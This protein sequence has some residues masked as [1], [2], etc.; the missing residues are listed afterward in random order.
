MEEK[1]Q[2]KHLTRATKV[3]LGIILT[4][5]VLVVMLAAALYLPP[6][7]RW[8]V[9]RASEYASRETGMDISVGGVHLAFPLD[10]S[11][12]EVKCIK[13]NDSLP[14]VRDTIA[15]I[16]QAVVDVQLLPL[17]NSNVVINQVEIN[18]AH[19][20][21]S[22]FIHEARVK[23]YVGRL[24]I[25]N[26][27]PPVATV[28]LDSS[29]V[30]LSNVIMSDAKLDVALSDTVPPDTTESEN[31]WKIYASQFAVHNSQFTVHM[32]G[33]TLQVSASL[34]DA[35]A[36]EGFFDLNKGLYQIAQFT[37]DSSQFTLDNNFEPTLRKSLAANDLQF[38]ANHIALTDINL[39]VDSI[40]Y[41]DPDIRL[42][43]LEASMKEQGGLE[44]KSMTARVAIDS[45][46]MVVDGNLA[47][48]ASTM[49]LNLKMRPNPVT[50]L[51]LDNGEIDG[52]IDASIG[53]QD[54]M[55]FAG[56][57]LPKNLR[58]QWPQAP[59]T[60]KGVMHGNM[61][62]VYIPW[63]TAELPTA[64]S[65]KASGNA[66]GFMA[67]ADNPYSRQFSAKMHA[68]L[69]TYNLN[70]VKALLD[71]STAKIINIP[72]MH[73]VADVTAN[74][75]EYWADV[76]AYERTGT[77][78]GKVKANIAANR[79]DVDAKARNINVGHYV[80]GYNQFLVHSA[81]LAVHN[82]IVNANVD[83]RSNL[84]YG[85]INV[86]G[87]LGSKITDLAITTDLKKADLYK[88][89][90]ADMPL[91]V[92]LNGQVDV[93]TDMDQYYKVQG[94]V[95]E[96]E[97]TDSVTTHHLGDVALDVLTRRDTTAAKINCGDFAMQ[98]NAQGGYK[99]LMG[100]TDRMQATLEK[101]FEARTI[102]QQALRD[103]LPKM[104]LKMQSGRDN[105]VYEVMKLY[106]VDYSLIDVDMKTSREDGIFADAKIYGLNTQ[107]YKLDTVTVSIGSRNDPMQIYYRAHIQNRPPNDYVFNALIDGKLLEHGIVTGVRLFDDKNEMALRLGAEAT[108]EENGIKLHLVPKNPTIGYEIF[109]LNDDNY[110]LLAKNNRIHANLDLLANNGT[111]IKIYC[112]DEDDNENDN[113]NDNYLQDLTL[114]INKLDIGKIAASIPYMPRMEGLLGGDI[115]VMQKS[116]ETFTLASD[117][118]IQNTR[119]EGCDIGN[120]GAEFTYLPMSDGSHYV[121]GVLK[122]DDIEIGTINGSYNF[123]TEAINAKMNFEKFPMQIIN[124]FVPDQIIGLEGTAEG[125]LAI[126]G[127]TSKP[128]VNGE[129]FLENAALLSVPYGVRLRFDDDPVRIQNSRL[130]FENFQMYA[131]NNE[132][133]LAHGS[134]DFAD[135]DHIKLD[136][137]M[138]A[139]NFQ[140]IDAKETSRSE[141][142]GEMYVNFFIFI[143]GELDKLMA[144]GKIDILPST[145]L[146][147]ILRDSPIT[148][149]N[150]LKEL[151]T[152]TDFQNGDSITVSRPTVDGMDMNFN[153]SV[154]E[155]AHIKCWLDGA[156]SNYLDLIGNGDLRYA[157]A[158]EETKLT[159]R[160]TITEGEMK[161][162]LPVI[163]L[164][165][166]I[167]ENGSYIEWTGEMMNPRLHITA[168]ETV[169][170]NVNVDGVNQMVTF[171]TG[172]KLSKT[173]NDMGLEFV[174]EAPENQTISDELNMKSAEERGKLAVT[175]LTTGMY[176][177]DG[178]TSAFSMNSAMNSFLQSQINTIAGNALKTIDISFGMESSTEQDGTM[179]NDYTFK[180]AKRFWNNRLSIA[181]GGKVSSGPDVSGQNKSFFNNVELQYR[182]SDTSNKYLKMFYKRAV[183]DYLEG[184]LSQYGAGYL[185]KKKA[186][187]L[188][189][190]F[191]KDPV[192]IP[193]RPMRQDSLKR[194]TE[195]E[196]KGV[197]EK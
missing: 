197:N 64:F 166:F 23:G 54:L 92:A 196:M 55:M 97:V 69:Q 168:K 48:P 17:L 102:D 183:Y 57:S 148:T 51:D 90:F 63:I 111:G 21:T 164:K 45:A 120:V 145:N 116:D 156:H 68:D 1:Q 95:R 181:V 74:G 129:L 49:A 89:K 47:T 136:M 158:N 177:S 172:V 105:P 139:Q 29:T 103:F 79:Y 182:L 31:L 176:L 41:C 46:K 72:S 131:A 142:Y 86:S 178:N 10:L 83:S 58:R 135:L 99:W 59:L 33:D 77:I 98:L 140:L 193:V 184:Y 143:R 114:S 62:E 76:K 141:A 15:L 150:R 169:K 127:T 100:C 147:Y 167:I 130:L 108:M 192:Y 173:L 37:V 138:R 171:N 2:H 91:T 38:D 132:P 190:I 180:F 3:I 28:S 87:K 71:R 7:Q 6:V 126:Q 146:Y 165:T 93:S 81:Q 151:V 80:K 40:Y 154:I 4:P 191:G 35:K 160:Y 137:R 187:T 155:G 20:N 124:G 42:N 73:A 75:P 43:I 179:H 78:T 128:N 152:F 117:I 106:G 149:D 65:L 162:S 39:R 134:V 27:P 88:L 9:D 133:L 161:Y 34:K 18:Q 123:D 107:G 175:M 5:I 8:A 14:Q 195:K 104:K 24:L 22:D 125:T 174:I 50:S 70:F 194:P 144:R 119:Y 109:T 67:L 110:V 94:V 13:Q 61:K 189:G 113:E 56:A 186:Q 157:Y 16:H 52:K 32:P 82:G 115:H 96:I 44:L 26:T 85:N 84:L 170:S 66:K 53:R 153:I 36:Q 11:L 60:V 122:K 101:Q 185:W 159:G 121:D 188:K 25:D 112:T 30:R 19:L 163:P 118:N 12:E